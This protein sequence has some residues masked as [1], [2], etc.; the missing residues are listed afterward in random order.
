MNRHKFF[1]FLLCL[2]GFVYSIECKAQERMIETVEGGYMFEDSLYSYKDLLVLIHQDTEATKYANRYKRTVKT[3]KILL[4]T[5]GLMLASGYIISKTA[6][7]DRDPSFSAAFILSFGST[8][9]FTAG[10][11]VALSAQKKKKKSIEALN[12]FID[13]QVFKSR[14]PAQL[15]I[16]FG[17]SGAGFYLSF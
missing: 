17:D 6:S 5:G 13:D 12:K 9:P 16:G 8:V 1:G 2:I 11:I 3:S 7:D 14:E 10:I 15:Q 4:L